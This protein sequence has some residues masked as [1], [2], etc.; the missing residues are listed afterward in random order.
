MIRL[1]I[2]EPTP[3]FAAGLR[4]T[5]NPDQGRYLTTVMRRAVGDEVGLFNGRDG[6]WR[7]RIIEAGK[8][9]VTLELTERL[10]AQPAPGDLTLAVALIKRAALE[11]IVEKATELGVARIQ[12]L[13]TRRSNADHTRVDRLTAI[14]REAAEQT[15]R[16][17][18]PEILPPVRLDAWLARDGAETIVFGDEE[19]THEDSMHEGGARATPPL[20]QVASGLSGP[21]AVLIGP[22]GGFD[23]DERKTL[24][25]MAKTRAVNLG[26]RILRADTAAI[27]ALTLCQAA[28]GDWR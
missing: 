10:R 19:S 3:V 7:A 18:V 23:D 28:A 13:I 21:V 15:E 27:A 6:E 8:K 20:L 26:P 12:L 25:G 14:A 1:F 9:A 17:D 24:R 22:E 2:A 4:L 11:Y 16:L 5:L